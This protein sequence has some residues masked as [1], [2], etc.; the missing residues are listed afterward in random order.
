MTYQIR[1]ELLMKHSIAYSEVHSSKIMSAS[2]SHPAGRVY[3]GEIMQMMY[4]V[5]HKVASQHS[6]TDVTAARVDEIVFLHPILVGTVISCH[7]LL[8]YVGRTSMEVKVNL[9]LEGIP[10]TEPAFTAYFVMV[11]LDDN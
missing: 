1:G 6:S 5:A 3:A 8:T 7:A 9:Y 4:N 10:S 11:A 2:P